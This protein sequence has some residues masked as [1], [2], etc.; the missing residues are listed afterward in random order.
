MAIKGSRRFVQVVTAFTL[1][2]ATGCSGATVLRASLD[3]FSRL[4]GTQVD[5]LKPF[6]DDVD[7]LG[8]RA[9]TEL[10]AMADSA[11]AAVDDVKEVVCNDVFQAAI[12]N[13]SVPTDN[14]FSDAL[15]DAGI[16]VAPAEGT[17]PA[18]ATAA[19]AARDRG[20]EAFLA[21]VGLVCDV[22]GL[23]L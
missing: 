10:R 21:F 7:T 4:A 13:R 18:L 12:E 5:Q 9:S 8:T 17:A 23:G 16:E 15:I 1:V 19:E 22:E 14:A 2:A 20:W 3:D 6:V 11:Q